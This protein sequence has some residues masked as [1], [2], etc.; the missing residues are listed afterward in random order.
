MPEFYIFGRRKIFL[1]I[2]FWGGGCLPAPR[3][4]HIWLQDIESRS[5]Y[6][7]AVVVGTS[8]TQV[9]AVASFTCVHSGHV[10]CW[11]LRET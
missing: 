11:C 9:I 2:F 8:D 6:H 7:V 5:G 4:L 1:P 3:F 10:M